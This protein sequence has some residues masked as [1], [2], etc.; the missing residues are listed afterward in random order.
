[1][2]QAN[3]RSIRLAI[4]KFKRLLEFLVYGWFDSLVLVT[5][6]KAMGKKSGAAVVRLNLL[7]DFSC[8]CRTA[9][10]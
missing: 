10:R 4:R 2:H 5:A 8:G 7:G 3:L 6:P 1:M 9:W